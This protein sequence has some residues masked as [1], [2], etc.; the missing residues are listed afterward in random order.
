MS[1]GN[2]FDAVVSMT[3]GMV[4]SRSGVLKN[5]DRY[6]LLRNPIWGKDQSDAGA[7][8]ERR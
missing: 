7:N 6:M 8:L 4:R 2:R 5:E 3:V 1:F